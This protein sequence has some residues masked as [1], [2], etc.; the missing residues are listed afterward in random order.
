MRYSLIAR[1]RSTWIG[2]IQG[3]HQG[4]IALAAPP[5]EFT[6]GSRAI[7]LL[8]HMAEHGPENLPWGHLRPLDGDASPEDIALGLAI[9]A[10]P[11]ALYGHDTESWLATH[12]HQ[13]IVAWGLPEAALLT[14]HL[15]AEAIALALLEALDPQ[16]LPLQLLEAL[17]LAPD[18]AAAYQLRQLQNSLA[19]NHSWAIAHYH[20]SHLAK[21]STTARLPLPLLHSLYAYLSSPEDFSLTLAQMAQ[22]ASPLA[23]TLAGAISGAYN[24]MAGLHFGRPQRLPRSALLAWTLDPIQELYGLSDTLLAQWAGVYAPRSVQPDNWMGAIA[25][26]QQIRRS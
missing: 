11:L 9:T 23:C 1:F 14:A 13:G 22:T 5:A 19:E 18:Q 7:A 16:H 20:Q 4:V 25:A 24:G 26:P 21:A 12:L 2:A 6:W 8:R 15:V 10:L 3:Y 17:A